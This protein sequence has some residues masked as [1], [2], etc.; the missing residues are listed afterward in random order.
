MTKL[1]IIKRKT[2]ASISSFTPKAIG[3]RLQKHASKTREQYP[4]SSRRSERVA[5]KSFIFFHSSNSH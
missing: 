1:M 3:I 4:Y 5:T 2:E